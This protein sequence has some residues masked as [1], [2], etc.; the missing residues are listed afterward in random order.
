MP[1]DSRDD[2]LGELFK[3]TQPVER[4][5]N[6]QQITMHAQSKHSSPKVRRKPQRRRISMTIRA[7]VVAATITLMV[8]FFA[9]PLVSEQGIAFADV[10]AQ[11]ER[12]RSVE[13][14]ETSYDGE[15]PA[16]GGNET[17]MELTTA[18]TISLLEK[19]LPDATQELAE[20]IKFELNTLKS[21]QDARVLY[22]RRVRIKGQ[23]LE[24]TDQLFP[25][26]T[27]QAY[28][29]PHYTVRNA[30]NGLIVSFSPSEKM[31]TVLRKQVVINPET[32]DQSES[33]IPRIPPAVDFFARFRRIPTEATE[34]VSERN[35]DG[36]MVV[37]FRSVES[38]G[39]ETWTRTHWVSIDSKL[40][41][42]VVTEMHK[43][44]ELQQRWVHNHF[45][46]DRELP[47]QLFDTDAPADYKSEDGKIYGYSR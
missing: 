29:A 19:H 6:V 28:T 18:E 32:G 42:E 10:Q 9:G 20:E 5:V 3:R 25:R 31:R 46:F 40:P 23:H 22:V 8:S 34:Q 16:R 44:T 2:C 24:R 37:G 33:S 41:I 45:K 1:H 11:I 21:L 27:V 35:I 17:T 12:V 4:S 39:D 15:H 13:Y 38:H 14:I 43:G 30:R 26:A 36:H 47:D 7:G